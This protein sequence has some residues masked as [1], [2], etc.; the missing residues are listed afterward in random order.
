MAKILTQYAEDM[1]SYKR[2]KAA[3]IFK[4]NTVDRTSSVINWSLSYDVQAGAASANFTL[5][6]SDG[7]YGNGGANE[8]K[9]G[10][11]IEFSEKF[12][13]DTMEFKKF[14]G[15]VEQRSIMKTA[16]T[17]TIAITCLD[18]ISRLKDLDI[19]YFAEGSRTEVT[20]E[21][22]SP[23]YLT[24]E[25]Q[26]MF[27]QV[28]DFAHNQIAQHPIP[29]LMIR[30]KGH[31]TDDLQYDGFDVL[32]ENGQVKF[33]SPINALD[34]YNV[35]ARSYWYYTQGLYIED[36]I[37]NLLIQPDGYGNYLF[38]EASAQDVIDNHLTE[39]YESVEGRDEYDDL[40]DYLT[41]NYTTSIIPILHEITTDFNPFVTPT[42]T[43]TDDFDP[44]IDTVM[45][46]TS[47]SGFTSPDSGEEEEVV[48]N[49]HIFTYTDIVGNTL[50]G[51]SGSFFITLGSE[52]FHT[53]TTP[54]S[55]LTVADT[56]GLPSSG[57]A[58]VNG[59]I[60]TW[61]TKDTT[62]LYGVS[63]LGSVAGTDGDTAGAFVRY[64]VTCAPNQVW[65]LRYNNV[66][67]D[68]DSGDFSIGNGGTFQYFDK[69]LGRIILNSSSMGSV[70]ANTVVKIEIDYSFKTL[71]ATGV[72]LNFIKFTSRKT[73]NRFEALK[74]LKQYLAPN[75]IL[76]TIGDDKIWSSYMSQRVSE[77][78]QLQLS[79]QIDYLED[80]DLYTRVV[81]YGKNKY[82]TNI[83]FEDGV[84]F[85]TTGEDYKSLAIND[86]LHFASTA[87][88]K[89]KFDTYIS[90][91]GYIT[92]EDF[93]PVLYINNV[94]VDNKPHQIL[95]Q[96]VTLDRTEKTVT[97]TESRLFK[98]PEV[99]VKTT[100][101]YKVYLPHQSIYPSQS[102]QLYLSSGTLA[103]NLPANSPDVDYARGI[104][105]VGGDKKN[106]TIEDLATASYFVFYST[107]SITIDYDNIVF[108]ISSKML[109]D[110]SKALV[111]A[112][113]EYIYVMTPVDGIA[114]V[115]DG[116]WD[117]QV[118]TEFFSD[119]P[120]GYPYAI[121]DLG[122]TRSIQAI[123]MVAGFYRPDDVRK[124]DID[125]RLTL[126][127]SLDNSTYYPISDSLS[128]FELQGGGSISFEEEDFGEPSFQAR[129]L[130]MIIENLKKIE[131]K[132]DGVWAVAF[133]E[134]SAY[135]NIIIKSESKLIY[136]GIIQSLVSIG[137]SIVNVDTTDGFSASGTAYLTDYVHEDAFTYT[138]KTATSFTGCSGIAYSYASGARVAKTLATTADL[139]DD[140]HI[141]SQLG[142]RLYKE[143]RIDDNL[144]YTQDRLDLIARAYHAEFIK[145]HQKLKVR[146]MYA[147]YLQVGQTIL[148]VD[149]FNQTNRRYFIESISDATGAYELV[150]AY[151]PY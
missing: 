16:T 130:K 90:N 97:T 77:D 120:T 137:A 149:A 10:D 109:P 32:Y 93:V 7:E 107:N 1:I 126:H 129:Y 17:R 51:V 80:E 24:E 102:I 65:Y 142:D 15:Q 140:D 88:G 101:K 105:L 84:E 35:V 145:N 125:M 26:T 20:N 59:D 94:P 106:A 37:E 52:A 47:T 11:I 73:N 53:T 19:E 42:T 147:P 25:G 22:L 13:G 103:Y 40:V 36:I 3:F 115:I 86:N 9:V 72:E 14:Y 150:L 144:L 50:T 71:Q 91:A 92:A 127:Y 100:Y 62:H 69:R 56:T 70:T 113:Y 61:T 12:A 2:V 54:N 57:S 146:L 87:E 148:L 85:T 128:N 49:G 117:T 89:H 60:F 132:R 119:P 138:G 78:Y 116:R 41:P 131:Y 33:G 123:D 6:N 66:V 118:Q 135:E 31:Q 75:Y 29:I 121:V 124:F 67:D 134:I 4:I 74:E 82:P 112:D 44:N 143:V 95:M 64:E 99:T 79:Q 76:R 83:M 43:L 96:P 110:P 68:L 30:D 98:S 122:Q 38:G 39:T 58:S 136:T 21:Y 104:W 111:A 46:L 108:Y 114:K 139:Y 27:A 45:Y 23:N 81:M 133:T 151:Y 141:L 34:N 8:I 5:N 28:F 48:A 18:Y 63:G 55:T